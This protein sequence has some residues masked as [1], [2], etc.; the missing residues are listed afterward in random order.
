SERSLIIKAIQQNDFLNRLDEEQINMMV[1]CLSWDECNQGKV[2]IREGSEG[3][4]LYIVA[5]GELNVTQA[6][7]YLRTLTR[8][9]VFGELAILY[10]CKRTATVTDLPHFAKS[11]NRP[12]VWTFNRA[13]EWWDVIVPGFTNTQWLEN[14]RKSEE[15]FIHLCNKLRPAMERR[16]TNFRV[17]VLKRKE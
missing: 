14:F 2:I 7:R 9:D 12:S 1:E 8:G 5:D 11:R 6:G 13:S 10:N 17:C 16:D 4:T 3:D 15:T